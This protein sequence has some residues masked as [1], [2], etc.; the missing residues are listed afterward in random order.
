MA[1]VLI[2]RDGRLLLAQRP[3]GKHLAGLWEFPGGK[4]EPDE[5]QQDGLARE[6]VEEIDVLVTACTPLLEL[7]WQYQRDG[8][9]LE[10]L[11]DVWRVTAWQREPRPMEGQALRWEHPQA[12]DMAQLAPADKVVLQR[13][14]Q[15]LDQHA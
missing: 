14:L 12:I 6:L 11:L 2:D 4:L 9:D 13:L 3:Q 15:H 1:G 8:A 7:P 10:L 5:S